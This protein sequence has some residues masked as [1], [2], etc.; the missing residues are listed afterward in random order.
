MQIVYRNRI[1]ATVNTEQRPALPEGGS[2]TLGGREAAG[3]IDVTLQRKA[4]ST[5]LWSRR[6]VNICAHS[7]RKARAI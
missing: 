2:S 7:G 5:L 4:R 1:I 3:S 6:I